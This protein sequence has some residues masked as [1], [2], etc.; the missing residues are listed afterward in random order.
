MLR[1]SLAKPADSTPPPRWQNHE[2]ETTDPH[3]AHGHGSTGR[4]IRR[5]R[6]GLQSMGN[7]SGVVC[8]VHH[9]AQHQHTDEHALPQTAAETWATMFSFILSGE[10]NGREVFRCVREHSCMIS[11]DI[12]L[13]ADPPPSKHLFECASTSYSWSTQVNERDN[14][15]RRT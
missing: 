11:I 6:M 7:M 1:R 2:P 14:N 10:L 4:R 3:G 13:N 8:A 5:L 15:Y 12:R 9:E